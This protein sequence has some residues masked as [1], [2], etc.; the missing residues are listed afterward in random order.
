MELVMVMVL[1]SVI[2][3]LAY[4]AWNILGNNF[5]EYSQQSDELMEGVNFIVF[6]EKDFN[7]AKKITI[8][9]NGLIL[10]QKDIVLEYTFEED[11]VQRNAF[12]GKER[13][14]SDIDIQ[15][16]NIEA[17]FQGQT[18]T[19]GLLDFCTIDYETFGIKNTITLQKQYSSDELIHYQEYVD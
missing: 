13:Y 4:S 7:D 16:V 17:L 2:A 8:Q 12:I 9:N 15:N 14:S 18:I 10:E 5:I 3:G 19:L 11:K 1:T 6:L